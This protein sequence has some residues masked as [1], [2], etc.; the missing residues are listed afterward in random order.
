M[1]EEVLNT[2]PEGEKPVNLEETLKKM[3]Q[4]NARLLEESRKN[5]E[6]AKQL[7]AETKR[8]EAEREEQLL[9]K[10]KDVSKVLELER[11]K[12]EKLSNETKKLKQEILQSRIRQAVSKYA[13]NVVD[14][15]DVL[16]QPQYFE[17]LKRGIDHDELTVSEDCVKEYVETVLK[18]KPHYIAKPE[19]TTV[20][21][22]K[23]SFS[24]ETGKDWRSLET[25]DLINMAHELFGQKKG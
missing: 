23:P 19:V 5:K 7:E 8:L 4:T 21:T 3:E 20:M 18:A 24:F 6:R 22:K 13:T 12:A 14:V 2:N 15:D 25:K 10:E 16:N 9:S 17:I 1:S 11:K